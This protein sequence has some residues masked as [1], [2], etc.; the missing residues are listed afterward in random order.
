ME[1]SRK[2]V[3]VGPVYPYKGGIS[4]YTSLMCTALREENDVYMMSY[5]LQYPKFLY[6]K[7]QKDYGNSTFCID[8]TDYAINTA[9]PF[10]WISVAL[11]IRRMKPDL[12]IIQWWHPYF[13]PCYFTLSRLLGKIK[14]LFVCHNVFPHERFFLDRFLTKLVLKKGDRFIVHSEQDAGDLKS[15]KENAVYRKTV[16]PTYNVFKIQDLTR[17]EGRR[18]LQI[19]DG[20]KV[21]LFFGFIREYKGLRYLLRAMPEVMGRLE[22]IRLLVVGDFPGN[23]DAYLKLAEELGIMSVTHIYDGYIPDREVEKFFA[24]SDLVVLPYISATQ[25]AI[26]QIAYGFEKPVVATNVGGLP[27]VVRDGETGY[28]VE[29]EN[30]K[31]LAERIIQFFEEGKAKEFYDAICAEAERYSWGRMTE[32]I[33]ELCR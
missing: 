23:K 8:D 17:E 6:K 25:S 28:V 10:N 1:H 24:A 12:V 2:I 18:Q 9:N 14:T 15:I 13:A 3:L 27:E 5:K 16:L 4:H 19:P 7:E 11:K 31:A 33:G 21:L 32:I 29:A 26:V 20:E 30:S 22:K